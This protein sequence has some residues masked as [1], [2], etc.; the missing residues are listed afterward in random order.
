M[1]PVDHPHGVRIIEVECS[2]EQPLTMTR[3]VT[4]NILVRRLQSQDTLRKVKRRVLLLLGE[5]V[6]FVV[7]RRSRIRFLVDGVFLW[8]GECWL[9]ILCNSLQEHSEDEGNT[10]SNCRAYSENVKSW[11]TNMLC[12]LFCTTLLWESD[13]Y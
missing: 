3:V 11:I 1:N 9:R 2:R 7:L 12:Y 10:L 5:L 6:C 13:G 8:L 4:I